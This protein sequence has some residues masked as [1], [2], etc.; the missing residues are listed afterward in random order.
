[1]AESEKEK[2]NDVKEDK[3][4]EMSEAEKRV[5]S[6][7]K[8]YY[9]NPKVQEA[10]VKFSAGR[11]IVPRYY[12]G[13]GKRPDAVQ[14]P[15]DIMGMANRGATSFHASEEIWAD[16]LMINSDMGSD[17]LGKC[18]KSWD[19]LI[20]IDSKYLD[21]SKIAAKL[22]IGE[23]E[24][25]GIR[26]YGLKFSGSKGFHIIVSGKAFP[27]EFDGQKKELSFP[28]W[29]R[30]ICQYVMSIIKPEYS[31]IVRDK[32]DFDSLKLRTNLKKEDVTEILCPECGKPSKK[33]KIADFKCPDCLATIKRINPKTTKKGIRCINCMAVMDV[34]N[35]EECYFCEECNISSIDKNESG[36]FG[37]IVYE[38]KSGSEK[39][40]ENISEEVLG[41][42]DLVLVAPRHLFRMPYSL[43]EK[44]ALASIVISKE[45]IDNFIPQD[46]NP[47]KIKIREF[48]PENFDEEAANLLAHALAWKKEKDA[49]NERIES[50]KYARYS[51]ASIE[52]RKNSGEKGKAGYPEIKAEDVKEDM[53]PKPI[54]KLLKGL[55][56]GKKRGLFILLTL[57][58]SLNYPP[59][60]INNRVREWNKLN[61][62]PLKEGYIKSQI[63]WHLKQKKRIIPPN[64]NN[65][66]FYKDIGLIDEAPGSKN[67][68]SDVAR[69]VRNAV[70]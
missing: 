46:A 56:D 26:N 9:S 34:I 62:P 48:M 53:F 54:K 59:E 40:E 22:V 49:D 42:L 13:F 50:K 5:R 70:R 27:R 36:R 32:I 30:A 10:L 41:G 39:F 66:S 37:K 15:S 55:K 58:R 6:I 43:H 63:E 20:D 31:R 38:E 47:L 60:S 68:L 8:M 65:Q 23:L 28:D 57:F 11:E 7:T 21:Y 61:E 25:H 4:D 52:Q 18:R 19:L 17:E 1:M 2:K 24:R 16:P 35:E 3:H 69:A 51:N 64:Y 12:E 45:E 44:T 14:Y 67:P 29:P 33:G